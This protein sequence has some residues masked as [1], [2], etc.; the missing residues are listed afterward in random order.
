[1]DAHK[2]WLMDE[3]VDAEHELGAHVLDWFRRADEDELMSR[4]TAEVIISSMVFLSDEH[5]QLVLN[6][7][8][9]GRMMNKARRGIT[10]RAVFA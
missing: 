8:M 10:E 5:F 6:D 7:I 1:M 3:R 2:E 4:P 9:A